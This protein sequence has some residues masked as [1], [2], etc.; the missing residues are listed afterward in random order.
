[1]TAAP[2]DNVL[3]GV[4]PGDGIGPEVTR[5]AVRVL[6][7]IAKGSGLDLTVA[8]G[9]LG[10]CAIEQ[11]GRPLPDETWELCQRSDALLVGAVGGEKWDSLPPDQNPGLGGLL[12]LRRELDL[13]ANLRPGISYLPDLSPLR[14]C[15]VDVLLV[16]EAVGG[17]YF[18][19]H[20]GRRREAD[21]DV[22]YDTMEYS[23][24]QVRRIATLA[25]RLAAER[26]GRL[27]SVDK[28]NVLES[29]QLWREV[30][31][32]VAARFPSVEVEHLY[33]DNCAM[34]L[35]LRP[36]DFDVVVT[37]NLFGDI[38]SDELAG[39][40]GSLGLLP[41]GSLRDDRFGLYEPVHGAAPD[42]AGLGKANPAAAILSAAMLL[43]HSLGLDREAT[44]VERAVITLLRRGVRT[45][46]IAHGVEAVSTSAFGDAVLAELDSMHDGQS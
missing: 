23:A 6:E 22:A 14:S 18:S 41:S 7:A 21:G 43:R 28:A 42:I 1:M 33:V 16:R 30:M 44:L 25:C 38:L 3:I 32:E 46:D 19:P 13:Y 26:G 15:D 20:R 40:V 5:E 24:A 36:G 12:R 45:P 27:T 29:S 8:E 2:P 35:V 34:Q 31:G 17:L 4:L 9:L 37:E 39:I 11:T 10:G